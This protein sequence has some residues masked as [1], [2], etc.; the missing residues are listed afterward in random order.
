M[1]QSEITIEVPKRSVG[2]GVYIIYLNFT[3]A[4][5]IKGLHVDSPGNVCKFEIYDVT[6]DRGNNRSGYFSTLLDWK[7]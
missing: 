2:V 7:I 6:T 4:Q 1:G 3:S 5:N